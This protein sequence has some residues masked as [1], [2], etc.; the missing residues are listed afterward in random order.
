MQNQARSINLDS[1][2]DLLATPGLQH[3]P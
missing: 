2:I 3:S 1:T